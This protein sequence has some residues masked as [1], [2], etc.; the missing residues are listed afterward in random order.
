MPCSFRKATRKEIETYVGRLNV[1]TNYSANSKSDTKKIL[2]RFYKFVRN[3][4]ADKLTPY[5]LE[6]A[7]INTEIKRNEQKEPE[8]LME[9]E[10]K[11]LVEAA[12]ST[13]TKAFISVI[14][15][16]GFRIGEML[17]A[18]IGDVLFDE[19]GARL[20]VR[21]K[22]GQ[23]TVRLITSAPI[24]GQ[25]LQAHVLKHEPQAPLWY[26]YGK[27]EEVGPLKYGERARLKSG[28]GRECFSPPLCSSS[29]D[30]GVSV[31]AFCPAMRPK[32]RPLPTECPLPW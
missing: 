22:T 10:T 11:K 17:S 29:Y 7:W 5:P 28:E 8:V 15:E 12:T 4:N 3:G 14:S 20:T 30:Q 9:D 19:H 27:R 21:G 13:R 2:K 18:T 23:R 16:G 6:V 31:A 25:Y 32:V 26:K 1:R 24:L